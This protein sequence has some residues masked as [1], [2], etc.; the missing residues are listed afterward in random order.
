MFK[1]PSLIDSMPL[2]LITLCTKAMEY[3]DGHYT[4]IEI[5]C[6]RAERDHVVTYMKTMHPDRAFKVSYYTTEEFKAEIST[7]G[8]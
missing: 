4:P 2:S 6:L 8:A 1:Y 7:R 5:V 3:A